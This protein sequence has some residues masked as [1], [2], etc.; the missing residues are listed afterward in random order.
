MPSIFGRE[1]HEIVNSCCF[2]IAYT[3]DMSFFSKITTEITPTRA[4]LL[5]SAFLMMFG[6]ISFFTN[7]IE[8]YPVTVK[9]SLFLISLA[10]VF[11]GVIVLLLSLVCF[12]FTIKPVLITVLMVSS[13]V[14]Y[15]MDSFGVVI[16]DTML[17]NVLHTDTAETLDLITLKLIIYIFL[18]GIIPSI[19]IYRVNIARHSINR[20]M[21]ARLKLIVITFAVIIAVIVAFGNFYASFFREHKSLRYYANPSFYIYSSARFLNNQTADKEKPLM[22]VGSDAKIPVTDE[23]REL[24]IMVLGETARA[25]RLSL[26]GYKRET[27]PLLA[28]ESVVSFTNFW[29][30]GTST[31][32]SVP[33]IFS[34][35]NQDDYSVTKAN[36]EENL[37]DVLRHAGVSELWLDNNSDSK[38]VALRIPYQSYK[39]PETNPVCD[40]ECRDEGMLAN[41]QAYIDKHE[42]GDIFIVLHQMGNHGPA[43]YKRY[44]K[45]FEKFTPTCNTNQLEDCSQEQIDNTYD[46][47]ILYTDYF[48]SKVIDLLKRNDDKFEPAMFYVSDHGESLGENGLYLHGMPG[49]IA[50]DTQLHVPA[51]MWFGRSFH[52]SAITSLIEK[53][54]NR[55]SHDNVFHTVLGL[56]EME[57]GAYNKDLDLINT[58]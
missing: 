43:Y 19:F 14:S 46:N 51:I 4:I 45:E 39:T 34:I 49:F 40:I 54:N 31:A 57:T 24:V 22:I 11:G 12:R 23:D 36:E 48:L 25:D 13:G 35:L 10:V 33:C 21:I 18:L 32:T 41:V 50:P 3:F 56:M 37:L 8:H 16:D 20:E 17:Q 53:K 42:K 52:N 28:K 26:N 6:N 2:F 5:T 1:Q 9:N 29:A 27:N 38:G 58:N 47:A 30:C 7:V 15:F 44:T 55:Y